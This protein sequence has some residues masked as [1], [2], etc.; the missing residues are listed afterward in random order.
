MHTGLL[1]IRNHNEQ[2]TLLLVAYK[3]TNLQTQRLI[4][5]CYGWL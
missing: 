4:Q 2:A 5:C 1:E 3:H